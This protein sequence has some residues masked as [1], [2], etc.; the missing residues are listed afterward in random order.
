MVT[1]DPE[2]GRGAPLIEMAGEQ[3]GLTLRS[4]AAVDGA[5]RSE[6]R[7]TVDELPKPYQVNEFHGRG[8]L[9]SGRLASAAWIVNNEIHGAEGVAVLDS[10]TGSVTH[11]L[12]LGRDRAKGCC[13]VLGWDNRGAVLLRLEPAALARWDPETG[14]ITGI[15]A[16]LRGVLTLA[17]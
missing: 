16:D 12:D 6:Q 10:R 9:H 1:P 3:G 5:V 17:G 2:A 4:R 8:W 14:A 15:I 11:L 13:P 7:I